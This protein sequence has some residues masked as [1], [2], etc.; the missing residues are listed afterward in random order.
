M[1]VAVARALAG[2]RDLGVHSGVVSDVVVDLVERGAVTNAFKGVDRGC[3]VT[4]GLFGTRRLYDFADDNPHVHLRAISYTHDLAVLAKVG[5]FH[6]INSAVE[7]DLTG[8]VNAE[9]AAGRY[10]GA[11]GGQVDFVRGAAAAA[12]GRSII[13]LR[14]TTADGEQTRIVPRLQNAPVTTARSD[15][16]V[17]ATEH[18]IA[19]LRG[20]SLTERAQLLIA[21]ADP[22]FRE[23]LE[24]EWALVA[25]PHR[26]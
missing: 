16:D 6:S 11:V 25:L 23:T 20:R 15:V 8:Q 3:I 13:A 17:V 24:R 5:R 2:H 19:D 22:A 1:P 21:I 14:S 18:G 4:G 7:V 10:L 26:G 12:D 9:V